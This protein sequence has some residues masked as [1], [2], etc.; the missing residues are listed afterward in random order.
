MTIMALQF[1]FTKAGKAH[2]ATVVGTAEPPFLIGRE[3]TWTLKSGRILLGFALYSK[4]PGLVYDPSNFAA[5][6]GFW[7]Y[8]ISP[9]AVAESQNSFACVNTWD[10]AAFTFGFMQYAAHVPD[11]D[12]VRFFKR[13][14]VLPE[15]GDYFPRLVLSNNRIFYR[16]DAGDL[17]QLESSASSKPLM[18][19]LNPID[20]AI[21]DQERIC[22]A[23]MI[24]WTL[25]HP[26]TRKIQ[27]ETAIENFKKD[28]RAHAI[29]YSLNGAP[30]KVCQLVCDIRHQ[31][32]AAPSLIR[33]ALNTDGDYDKAYS[34]LIKLGEAKYDGRK[35]TIDTAVKKLIS[36]GVFSKTYDQGQNDFV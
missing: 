16:N 30:A 12:F 35:Q 19:Y 34:N 24:H 33:A 29:T 1:D 3:Q 18:K 36:S 15:A 7:A 6:F 32:R 10:T 31:G 4:G 21:D 5:D 26:E 13:L 20:D 25:H 17:N 11:G 9:T 28:L 22:V 14:L 23:R 2:Y 27:V 8:F